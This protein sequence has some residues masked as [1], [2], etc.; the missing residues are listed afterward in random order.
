MPSAGGARVETGSRALGWDHPL[1]AGVCPFKVI[2][3]ART[4]AYV[5]CG[6]CLWVME[7]EGE[8]Q[9]K[10]GGGKKRTW[11]GGVGTALITTRVGR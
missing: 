11:S 4:R 6:G 1:P 9:R 5:E 7:E 10:G 2:Q 3:C 8:E